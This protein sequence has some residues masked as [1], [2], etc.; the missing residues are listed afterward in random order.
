M[1]G[2]DLYRVILSPTFYQKNRLETFF[3]AV[4]AIVMT[5]L[6]LGL[7]LPESAYN[8]TLGEILHLMS[9]QILHFAIAFF[10]LGAFWGAHHRLFILVKKI[11]GILIKLTFLI[12]FITC[13]LPFTS[14]LAGDNHTQSSSVM[15]FHINMLILGILFAFQWLY[16]VNTELT[17][18]IPEDLFRYVLIRNLLVPIVAFIALIIT[19]YSPAMS[20]IAYLFLM[21]L[22]VLILPFKPKYPSKPDLADKTKDLGETASFFKEYPSILLSLDRVSEEMGVSREKLIEKI[23]KQWVHQN[24]VATGKESSLCNLSSPDCSVNPDSD[25]TDIK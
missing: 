12:L 1:Q 3:D 15:L 16:I 23:L 13:L 6:V 18:K 7:S 2:S 21:L 24:H 14:S 22:Q 19:A 11:D 25:K 5:I 8:L 9:P 17:D 4:Y 10:I 20:S